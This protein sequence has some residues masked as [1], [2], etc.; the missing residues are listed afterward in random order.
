MKVFCHHIYELK[1]GLRNLVLC[2]EKRENREEIE[3]RLLQEGIPYVI[4]ELGTDRINVYFGKEHCIRVIE[5]F[6]T[7]KLSE[8]SD[9]QDFMLGVMLGYDRLQQCERYLS[10][11]SRREGVD[12]LIG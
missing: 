7:A 3:R 4:H 2:P 6:A 11:R 1:K 12:E 10:R 5:T 9:E 8:I